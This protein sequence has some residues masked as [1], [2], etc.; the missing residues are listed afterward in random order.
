MNYQ[1]KD[2][3]TAGPSGPGGPSISMPCDGNKNTKLKEDNNIFK[4]I[5]QLFCNLPNSSRH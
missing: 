5:K 1:W 2:E 3:H 4:L